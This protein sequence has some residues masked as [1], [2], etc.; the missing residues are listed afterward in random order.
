MIGIDGAL[1]D[2]LHARNYTDKEIAA[3]F[4]PHIIRWNDHRAFFEAEASR[5]VGIKVLVAEEYDSMFVEGSP[6][7]GEGRIV[8]ARQIHVKNFRTNR[9]SEWLDPHLFVLAEIVQHTCV[10]RQKAL[11]HWSAPPS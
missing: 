4:G 5:L 9:A 3:L 6:D 7:L 8:D 10:S 1:I 2:Q 11:S